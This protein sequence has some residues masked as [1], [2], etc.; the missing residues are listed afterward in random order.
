LVLAKPPRTLTSWK[1]GATPDSF[2][3]ADGGGGLVFCNRE[4]GFSAIAEEVKV[5]AQK[6]K[7]T[8]LKPKIMSYVMEHRMFRYNVL[9]H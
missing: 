6:T 1:N 8:S 5:L 9:L 4:K 3:D 2:A 7:E